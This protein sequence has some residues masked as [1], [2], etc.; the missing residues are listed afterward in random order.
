MFTAAERDIVLIRGA[1]KGNED[2]RPRHSVLSLDDGRIVILL[3]NVEVF[4]GRL[5]IA[6]SR[7][8]ALLPKR[9]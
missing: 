9:E 8:R 2:R 4:D 1:E 7:A 5:P 3:S 6:R